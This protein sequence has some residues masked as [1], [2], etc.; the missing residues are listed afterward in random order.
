MT[1]IAANREMMAADSQAEMKNRS[2]HTRKISRVRGAL[3]GTAGGAEVS[4]M[5]VHW[6]AFGADLSDRPQGMD[7]VA[8]VLDTNGLFVYEGN[9]YPVEIT[10]EFMAIGSGAE[11]AVAAMMLGK[12]PKE[13]VAIACKVDLHTRPPVV[14][15]R[16]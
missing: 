15:E 9:C 1:T 16:L 6:Y 3:I 10:D 4:R 5:F 12:S 11:V 8:L 2:F 14:V 7:A 13:A